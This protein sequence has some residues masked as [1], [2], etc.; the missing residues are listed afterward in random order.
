MTAKLY[1]IIK[2]KRIKNQKGDIIKIV[3]SRKKYFRG[4][5]ELYFSKVKRNKIKGW[6][7]HKRNT[8]LLS[9]PLWKVKF[10]FK[11]N[12]KDKKMYKLILSENTDQILQINPKT[13]FAFTSKSKTS[14][15][16][17]FMDKIHKKEETLKHLI[18][19]KKLLK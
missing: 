13:W 16:V 6:N 12:I 2:I 18:E 10:F 5:G 11:T 9:V 17:N 3:N 19:N 1:K 7:Y 15:I 8:C 14:T 4:F